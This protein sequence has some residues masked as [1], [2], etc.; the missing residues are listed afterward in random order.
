[1]FLGLILISSPLRGSC[2]LYFGIHHNRVIRRIIII[3]RFALLMNAV[4]RLHQSVLTA[5]LVDV[6]VI[7]G[8]LD[9]ILAIATSCKNLCV[10]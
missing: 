2:N 3:N 10:I 6:I 5:W 1:M 9:T 4:L 7:F 8:G